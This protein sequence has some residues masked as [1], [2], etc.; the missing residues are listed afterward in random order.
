[1]T[2]RLFGLTH[3]FPD[4]IDIL[5]V[6]PTGE[7]ALIMSDA[8]GATDLSNINLTLSDSAADPLPD[9]APCATFSYKPTNYGLG[10]TFPAPAPAPSGSSALSVFNG[11]N[12]AGTWSLYVVDDA[13]TQAGSISFGWSLVITTN[14]AAP[15]PQPATPYPST[16]AVAGETGTVTK[17][18]VSL[19]GLSHTFPLDIDVLLVGPTGANALI[20]SD[21]C[22]T[23]ALSNVTLTFDDAAGSALPQSGPCTTGT[24][25]PANYFSGDAFP[26][27]APP[28]S[29]GS[30]LSVFNGTDPNGTWSL[31]VV[32]D[33]NLDSGSISNWTLN[34]TTSGPTAVTTRD[35]GARPLGKA[36]SLH[37][38]TASERDLVGFNL[39]RSSG[40]ETARVNSKLIPAKARG[41]AAGRRYSLLDRG[42]RSGQSYTY[43]LQVVHLDGSRTWAGSTSLRTSR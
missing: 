11:T 2:V 5:L 23:T 34:I 18:T 29:G 26:A 38:R 12:P 21:A 31:Y 24:F 6:G 14:A 35:F 15:P 32:D 13:A 33:A 19:N 27:P 42:V 20:M 9:S 3:T 41:A 16:I 36:V 40:G 10:D 17:V 4:D 7:N 1:V 30:A 43:R 25:R 37:W 8:C 39:V 22:G 28:P